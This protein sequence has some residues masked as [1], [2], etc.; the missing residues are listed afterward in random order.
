MIFF[1]V[2]LIDP[3]L[4]DNGTSKGIG[5]GTTT[6]ENMDVLPYAAVTQ[7][8]EGSTVTYTGSSG[9]MAGPGDSEGFANLVT[10]S[11]TSSPPS[12]LRAWW[13]TWGAFVAM[14]VVVLALVIVVIVRCVQSVQS[15]CV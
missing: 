11:V 10:S 7:A 2:I 3:K 1:V 13:H 15:V 14:A 4:F 12:E 9:G 5:N 6:I 8:T